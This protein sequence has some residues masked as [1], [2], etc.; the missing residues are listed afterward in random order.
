MAWAGI[1]DSEL[2][3]FRI[4]EGVKLTLFVSSLI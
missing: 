2:V 1:V 3:Y 4:Q